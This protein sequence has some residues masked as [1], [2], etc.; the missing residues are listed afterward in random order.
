MFS[1][2]AIATLVLL[3]SVAWSASTQGDRSSG[4]HKEM[5]DIM[6]FPSGEIKWKEGPPSLPK[7][8]QIAVL[9]GDPNKEGP[10]AF[11]VKI[12]DGYRVPPHT[13]PKT[14]RITVISGTF[15]VGMGDK[16]DE[17]KTR[18]M[19]TGTYGYWPAGMKHF[20]CAKGETVLQFHGMGPWSIK[21]VNPDDDPRHQK[22]GVKAGGPLKSGPQIGKEL[23][24]F[25]VLYATGPNAGT[26]SCPHEEFGSNPVAMIFARQVNESVLELTK[27]LDGETA[28]NK[29]ARMGSVAVF[30]SDDESLP[31][32]LNALAKKEGIKTVPLTVLHN[33]V[34]PTRYEIAK[35]ADVTVVLYVRNK[36][37][38]NHAF[39]K[40]ELTSNATDAIIADVRKILPAK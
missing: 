9:E 37:V 39:R 5:E 34:G 14:E 17:K 30:L 11:R 22:K 26:R 40:G 12:P 32:A 33:P 27:R 4:Q 35:E 15:N 10:F 18:P 29:K 13:H 25:D 28:K 23:T 6:L 36:V 31:D 20:V 1:R 2:L 24:P 7:G 16:F 3:M 8:A 21:Y 19:P 38:A